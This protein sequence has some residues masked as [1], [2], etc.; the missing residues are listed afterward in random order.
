MLNENTQ[1]VLLLT[2]HFAKS[3]KDGVKPLTVSEYARFA[4]WLLANQYQP[5]SLF[6]HAEEIFSKWSDRKNAITLER[7]KELLGR[8]MAMSLAL[9]KWQKVGMWF[10]TRS[11][12]DYPVRLKQKL[13]TLSPPVI[14]GLGNKQLLKTGGLAV[15][16]SR[17]IEKDE[18]AFAKA[19]GHQAALEGITLVSGGAK[20][21]DETAM[22]SCLQS[23]GNALGI[24]ADGLYNA[25]L[26][27][28]WRTYIKSEMLCLISTYFPEARFHTGNAMGRN[29]YIYSLS[30]Q[31][32]VVR[33]DK[34][35]GG[36]WAGATENLKKG[37][38]PLFVKPSAT[39][40][41]KALLQMG[42][43]ILDIVNGGTTPW[44]SAALA[45][46]FNEPTIAQVEPGDLFSNISEQRPE[47]T[48]NEQLQSPVTDIFFSLFA[49]QLKKLLQQ[50]AD[51]SDSDLK[52]IMPDL[53]PD[54]IHAWLE[55]A[56]SEKLVKRVEEN[57][58][59]QTLRKAS[60]NAGG[61]T[62]NKPVEGLQNRKS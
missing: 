49:N 62:S 36:T 15:V 48:S 46:A 9:E 56:E 35:K 2:C 44:L 20:G 43:K 39:D 17:N 27:S 33:S 45:E 6:G 1:A 8:G 19:I 25:A 41:N 7:V 13:G 51:L 24:L 47:N 22:L 28:K 31:A 30:D 32:L 42:G 18:A 4:E 10:L 40:G 14:F 21:V 58:T 59:Y 26:S 60:P 5:L 57:G 3:Q 29:K 23:E 34:D 55:R 53:H 50:T 12:S 54:Q 52:R 61:D 11:D 38:V 37:W 16:G